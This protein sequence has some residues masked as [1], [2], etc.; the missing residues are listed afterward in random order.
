MF[1]KRLEKLRPEGT[2]L[3]AKFSN[4][5]RDCNSRSVTDRLF[6][7]LVNRINLTWGYQISNSTVSNSKPNKVRVVEG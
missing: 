3:Q 7:S 5:I 1:V 2:T 4:P 6:W